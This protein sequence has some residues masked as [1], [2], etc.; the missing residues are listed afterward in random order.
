MIRIAVAGIAH[1]TNTFSSDPTT[2]QDFQDFGILRGDEI[3]LKHST[4][5]S[6]VG[7]LL[8]VAADSEVD[9]VPLVYAWANPGGTI[10]A[11]AFDTLLADLLTRIRHLGPWDAVLL[12]Q[13]GAA[14]SQQHLDADLTVVSE[15]RAVVGTDVP[16][17]VAV[18]M[19]AN[20]SPRLADQATVVAGYMTNPHIDAFERGLEVARLT[21]TAVRGQ[22]TPVMAIQS[23][24]A[25]IS[26]VRQDTDEAPMRDIVASA[27]GM[28]KSDQRILSVSVAEGYPYADVPQM[29]MSCVV[30]ADGDRG[31]AEAAAEELARGIWSRRSEFR[32]DAT[33]PDLALRAAMTRDGPT[34]LLDV[35]D[36]VGAGGP[37]NST[38]LLERALD[39]GATGLLAV[40]HEP[41][42]VTA[43]VSAGV[44]SAAQISVGPLVDGIHGRSLSL[45]GRVCT[46]SD[47]RFVDYGTTHGGHREFDGGITAVIDIGRD[48]ILIL[49]SNLTLPVSLQQALSVGVAPERRRIIIAKGVISPRAAYG[50]IATH[51]V[52]VA[53]SG[54]TT[55]D[56]AS[57]PYRRRRRPLFPFE[58][59]ARYPESAVSA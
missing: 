37:G 42:A 18:D 8:A 6:T 12:A 5:R 33:N 11:D 34:V 45:T 24:P 17:G 57:L 43:C 19:H 46:I 10:Q 41:A 28:L 49:T 15:V 31:V 55:C 44:G 47:G 9:L 30:V 3:V 52:T 54:V 53:T 2:L 48:N 50:P 38:V 35:G 27:Q 58:G 59:W 14:V 29:G 7:G 36:N 56:L 4:A 51:M 16:I 26:I 23:I 32:G 25:V 1:E 13:H 40:L 21:I 39:T 22:V 20:L